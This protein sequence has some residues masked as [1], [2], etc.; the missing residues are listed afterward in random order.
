MSKYNGLTILAFWLMFFGLLI[1]QFYKIIKYVGVAVL[2][3]GFSVFS[4]S[5]YKI[6]CTV[7]KKKEVGEKI[8]NKNKREVSSRK[9]L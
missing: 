6:N 4:Y 7:I 2:I 9:K 5:Q 8:G 1:M 3:I